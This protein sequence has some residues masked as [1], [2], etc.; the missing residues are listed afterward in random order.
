MLE[1]IKKQN[2][3][4]WELTG[5]RSIYTRLLD[6]RLFAED[7]MNQVKLMDFREAVALIA[8]KN[9]GI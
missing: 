1:K 2:E 6:M 7:A 8:L 5:Y 9:S 3:R 4:I